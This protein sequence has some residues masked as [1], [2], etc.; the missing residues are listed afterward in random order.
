MDTQD[1]SYVW[2]YSQDDG[3]AGVGIHA[4]RGLFLAAASFWL[5][6]SQ[7]QAAWCLQLNVPSLP[8]YI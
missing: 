7:T 3:H 1:G 5:L 8:L 4:W 2:V 6:V